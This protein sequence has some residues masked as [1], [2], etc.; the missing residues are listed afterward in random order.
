MISIAPVL[1]LACAG[2]A[3]TAAPDTAD[4]E[5]FFASDELDVIATLSPL[6]APAADPTNAVADDPDAAQLGQWLFYATALSADGTVSCATCHD[7]AQ[8]LS[9]GLA[10]SS[11]I[12][13][14]ARHAMPLWNTAHNRWFFWDGRCDTQWCQALK[15]LEH[16]DEMGTSR[17][18][19]A[20]LLDQDAE[21]TQAYEQLFGPLPELSDSARFP[22]E[23]RPVTDDPTDPLDVA[24]AGMDPADQESI[25]VVFANVG[26]AIAAYERL[27]LTGDAPF[28][29]YA[30]VLAE[31]GED[32]A[33][34]SGHLSASAERG[35]KVFAGAGNCHFCHSGPNF[36]NNE[37][38]NIGLADQDWLS[39]EDTGRYDGIA[40]LLAE[41]FR[42]DGA[43]SD[44]PSAAAVKLGHLVQGPEQLGQFKVPS[45]RNVAQSPPY[46]HGGQRETL[47]DVVVFYNELPEEPTWGHR[48]ELMVPLELDDDGVADLVAFLES[49]TGPGPDASLLVA[50][51]SPL[52]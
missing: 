10:L 25:N 27:L 7:P 26:K 36:T 51:P 31:S 9:D 37:F 22:A 12:G 50:P 13:E 42:G 1:L 6:G 15:P 4:A 8:G 18:A 40:A 16:P 44:D 34:A 49:L 3:D 52:R 17:L 24:W 38:H 32:A 39:P 43:Y 20:H 5:G 48:E 29:A 2:G 41:P 47:T 28:D 11:G 23:G 30:A 19:I 35:L 45:L 46:M 14:T 21:L 33:R